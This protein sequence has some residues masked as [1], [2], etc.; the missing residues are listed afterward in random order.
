VQSVF[1]YSL[2]NFCTNVPPYMGYGVRI[3]VYFIDLVDHVDKFA[4]PTLN[5]SDKLHVKWD[6]FKILSF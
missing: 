3:T 1:K 5:T 4:N 6:A 2:G